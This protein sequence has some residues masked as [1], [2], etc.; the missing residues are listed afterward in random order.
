MFTSIYLSSSCSKDKLRMQLTQ[1][2]RALHHKSNYNVEESVH[3][4]DFP[5]QEVGV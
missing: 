1:G 4:L 2:L 5:R 3:H